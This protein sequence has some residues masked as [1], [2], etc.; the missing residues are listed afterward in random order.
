MKTRS[1]VIN[2]LA[3][4][5]LVFV[6]AALLFQVYFLCLT[7][8]N[9]TEMIGEITSTIR[10]KFDGHYTSLNNI[11]IKDVKIDNVSNNVKIGTLAGNRNLA[12]GV[13]T[14]IEEY[15]QDANIDINP[16]SENILDIQIVYLD[17][18][19]TKKNISII[20]SGEEEVVVRLRGI[21]Y[22]NGKKIKDVVVEESSSEINMSTL[23]VAEDGKFNQTSL[24]NALKKSCNKLVDKLLK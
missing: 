11:E 7:F 22:Q 24:S 14:I 21:L 6:S 20:H 2:G 15:I 3:S 8:S 1:I 18:L 9:N 13:R 19:N 5:P 12:F 16:N 4:I 23:V 17:V 10:S